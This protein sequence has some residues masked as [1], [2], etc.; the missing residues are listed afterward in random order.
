MDFSLPTLGY[1]AAVLL[2]AYF[3]RGIAGFGSALIAVPLLALRLPLATVVPLIALL[4][5]TASLTQGVQSRSHIRWPEIWPLLPFTVL[6]VATGLLLHRVSNPAL[7]TKALGAFISSYAIYAL[8]PLS[9]L[10]G[11]RWWA[12]PA[13]YCGGTVGA[14]F[15]T[16][17]PFYV[18][19]LTLRQADKFGFRATAATIL[20]FDGGC[21]LIGFTLSGMFHRSVLLAA[22]AALPLVA[23]GLRFG[24]RIH[25]TITPKNFMRLICLI[26]LGSGV[27]LLLK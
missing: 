3:I 13:G 4:D 24:N 18:I 11:P 20:L 14:L 10:R 23:V 22:V 1:A 27:T 19:Y 2:F 21:R 16:G 26:L 15:G 17:G 5:Y 12:V 7:L 9:N 25:L 8:L 6:G